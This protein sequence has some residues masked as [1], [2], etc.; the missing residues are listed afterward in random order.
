MGF[1]KLAVQS[2]SRINIY[3][4]LFNCLECPILDIQS[5]TPLPTIANKPAIIHTLTANRLGIAGR[6]WML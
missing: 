4:N 6:K 3:P 1:K 5:L 2:E